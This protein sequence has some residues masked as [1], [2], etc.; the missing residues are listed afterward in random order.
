MGYCNSAKETR[1]YTEDRG[2]NPNTNKQTNKTNQ[3]TKRQAGGRR[4]QEKR[5]GGEGKEK[6]KE[7]RI[8][9]G[10]FL[11]NLRNVNNPSI[12]IIDNEILLVNQASSKFSAS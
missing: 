7:K 6:E 1:L 5:R 4:R 9:G 11:F 2:L 10:T 12:S 3:P 8:P